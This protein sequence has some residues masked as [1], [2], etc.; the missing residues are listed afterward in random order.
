M[1]FRYPLLGRNVAEHAALPK[2]VSTHTYKMLKILLAD[3]NGRRAA[4]RRAVRVERIARQ[5]HAEV[6]GEH[7]RQ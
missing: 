7:R 5:I 6:L 2:V 4:G 1:I 3:A